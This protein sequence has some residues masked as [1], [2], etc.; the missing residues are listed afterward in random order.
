MFPGTTMPKRDMAGD[1]WWSVLWPEPKEILRSL[2]IES[3]MTVLDLCCGD[4]HFTIPLA[5]I[6]AKVYGLDLEMTLLKKAQEYASS[7]DV[8]NC[9]WIQGDAMEISSLVPELVDCVFLANTFHG[10]REREDFVKNVATTLK[11]GG[12]FILVNWHPK[13]REETVVLGRARGPKTKLC[14]SPRQVEDI[15]VP[16]GFH[17]D[18]VIEVSPHHYGSIFTK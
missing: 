8:E 13:P 3:D 17:L 14:L 12:K 9:Q 7:T 16:V 1:D 18:E 4:G 11:T 10:V 15:L 6:A 2:K 5:Q